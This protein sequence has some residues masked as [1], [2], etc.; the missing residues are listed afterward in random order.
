VICV[1]RFIYTMESILRIKEKIEEQKKIEL[2]ESIQKYQKALEEE[3]RRKETL[4]ESMEFFKNTQA[5]LMKG[6]KLKKRSQRIRYYQNALEEQKK[7]VKSNKEQVALKRE[8][9]KQAVQEKKIQE[10]LKERAKI[11]FLEEEKLKEQILL[12]EVVSYRYA[13]QKEEEKM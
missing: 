6:E 5:Q 7:E 1:G 2:G 8:A 10:K 9:L 3:S 11:I 12:D 13:T 4:N